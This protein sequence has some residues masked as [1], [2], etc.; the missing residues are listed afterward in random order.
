MEEQKATAV[1]TISEAAK[2]DGVKEEELN[3]PEVQGEGEP[4]SLEEVIDYEAELEKVKADNAKLEEER[5]NYKEGLLNLKKKTKSIDEVDI[6][7]LVADSV[8]K[9]IQPLQETVIKPSVDRILDSITDNPS[10]KELI[11]YH[12][13]N[14]IKQSGTSEQAIR[15]DI[16]NALMIADKKALKRNLEELSLSV[17][18]RANISGQGSGSTAKPDVK[19]EVLTNEQ[20]DA[21]K[22]RGFTPDMIKKFEENW[23]K[24]KSR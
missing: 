19:K 21:L 24:Q 5:N 11:K 16:E 9:A 6:E 10:K 7:K 12:Y 17:K 18:N 2:E 1:E 23:L 14:S 13:E 22:K 15:E 8:A 3:A 20:I 4:E